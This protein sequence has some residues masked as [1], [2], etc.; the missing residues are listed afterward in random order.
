MN[1]LSVR[2]RRKK[3]VL[4]STRNLFA[5]A[6][7]NKPF[8]LFLFLHTYIYARW[9][10]LYIGIG[11]GDHPLARR[12]SPIIAFVGRV[13]PSKRTPDGK[14]SLE[15]P[16]H[17]IADTYHGKTLPLQTAREL[18]MVKEP[19]HKPDLEHVVPYTQARAIILENPDH[20]VVMEC[21]CRAAVENPCTPTDVCLIVGE[22]FAS[23][24]SEHQPKKSR[25]ITQEEAVRILEE[26]DARGHVHHAFFKDAMLGRYY[27][28]CNCCSCCCGAMKAHNNHIPML[29]SSGYI[30]KIDHDLCSDCGLCHD[31]CQFSALIFDDQYTSQVVYEQCM[32]C[33][34]CTSHCQL[35][36]IEPV[37]LSF[38]VIVRTPCPG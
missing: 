27:A 10:Y 22:P 14:H 23:F 38:Q 6:R 20:I 25:W 16:S 24:I 29:A 18:I 12:F 11:K 13:F 19:I 15:I 35:E 32:G 4:L 5:E 31:Y 33:G 34:I 28:I 9:P 36:A 8:N 21:A 1:K 30:A 2:N 37:Q 7:K 26:E 3:L 17:T